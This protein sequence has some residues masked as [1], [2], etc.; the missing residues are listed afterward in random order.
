[1]SDNTVNISLSVFKPGQVVQYKGESKRV[2]YVLLR[3][4]EMRVVLEGIEDSVNPAELT[5][6]PTHYVYQR[7]QRE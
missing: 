2:S 1:M 3:K 4:A 7:R 6:A 5:V